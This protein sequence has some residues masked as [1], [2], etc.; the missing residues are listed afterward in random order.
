MPR[1]VLAEQVHGGG[2]FDKSCDG[3]HLLHNAQVKCYP[4]SF[5]RGAFTFQAPSLF[6]RAKLLCL[7]ACVGAPRLWPLQTCYKFVLL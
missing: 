5:A 4:I 3:F 2:V 6:A 1:N 7:F